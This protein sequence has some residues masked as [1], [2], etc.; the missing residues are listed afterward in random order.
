MEGGGA[1]E[2]AFL[3]QAEFHLHR[4]VNTRQITQLDTAL[5]TLCVFVSVAADGC[6][7]DMQ[8]GDVLTA[9][10]PRGQYMKC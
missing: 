5:I 3:N 2:R 1:S 6:G 9:G 8:M 7:R 4:G 10:V